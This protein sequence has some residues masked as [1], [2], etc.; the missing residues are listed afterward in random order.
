M[1]A[2]GQFVSSWYDM[3]SGLPQSSIKDIVKDKYGFIWLLQRTE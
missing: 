2:Y 1:S 3:D